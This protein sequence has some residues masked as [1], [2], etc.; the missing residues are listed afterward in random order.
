MMEIAV[1]EAGKRFNR[2]WIFRNWSQSFTPD[3]AYVIL[4]GNGSGK[5]T[6]LKTILGYAPLTEGKLAYRMDGS[7]I[8]RASV[9]KHVNFCS[10]YLELY[11][12]LTLREMVSFHF[13]LK[14]IRN[15]LS[16]NE[17]LDYIELKKW[18]DK[19][20]KFF[21]SGMKQRLRLGLAILSQGDILLLDEPVSNLDRAGI[22]WYKN[23]V[24]KHRKNRICVVA[25]NQQED[26]FFFCD[27][28]I[29]IENYKP[30]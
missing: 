18:V 28:R 1:S 30:R 29:E 17:F 13:S 20:V 26:E 3:H 15:G 27:N 5:S 8:D 11:E 21:S 14:Q 2:N 24:E 16:T 10:P 25:S 19:P 9:Y 12:E 23:L 4:G 6:A 7:E 22:N